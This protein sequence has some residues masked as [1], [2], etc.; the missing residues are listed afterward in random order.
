L[1]STLS[2]IKIISSSLIFLLKA[3]LATSS[4][5]FLTLVLSFADASKKIIFLISQYCFIFSIETFLS[6]I[7]SH[8]F[9]ITTNG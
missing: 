4:K 2:G 8:L 9:A 1:S 3:N 6:V 7:L 5:D